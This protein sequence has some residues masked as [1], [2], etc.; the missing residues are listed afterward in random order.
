MCAL[1]YTQRNDGSNAS[2][3]D[4]YGMIGIFKLSLIQKKMFC[5]PQLTNACM[6]ARDHCHAQASTIVCI[7]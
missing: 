6:A 4:V 5:K 1:A 3:R 7:H 2:I